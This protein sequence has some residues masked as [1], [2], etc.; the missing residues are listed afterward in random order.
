MLLIYRSPIEQ[1]KNGVLPGALNLMVFKT[2]GALGSPHEYDIARR[3][4]KIS[5]DQLKL[6]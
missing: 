5:G 3:V 4:K 2:L 6:N 1:H